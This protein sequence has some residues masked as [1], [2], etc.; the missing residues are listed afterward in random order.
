[1]K[2][3]KDIRELVMTGGFA[4]SLAVILAYVGVSINLDFL[5]RFHVNIPLILVIPFFCGAFVYFFHH[6]PLRAYTLIFVICSAAYTIAWVFFYILS[7]DVVYTFSEMLGF[8]IFI[9]LSFFLSI[10]G[11]WFTSAVLFRQILLFRTSYLETLPEE[12]EQLETEIR[13]LDTTITQKKTE[14]KNLYRMA[15]YGQNVW[16]E[17][18]NTRNN[19]FDLKWN[20]M[21]KKDRLIILTVFKTSTVKD[22]KGN[23]N[24]KVLPIESIRVSEARNRF[25]DSC[26]YVESEH[27]DLE[28]LLKRAK[29]GEGVWNLIKD[30]E[31]EIESEETTACKEGDTYIRLYARREL[32]RNNNILHID[33][34]LRNPDSV[35]H[36]LKKTQ[37][38]FAELKRMFKS[39][40]L[41]PFDEDM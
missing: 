3:D 5:S 8:T 35:Y 21:V 33:Y 15:E 25:L 31:E 16:D 4:L 41:P 27:K 9:I 40:F 34:A 18:D 39:T 20:K 30:I 37:R 26:R 36:R 6:I 11:Y 17:I 13:E 28:A 24:I 38:F 22:E 12:R 29:K 23:L 2:R 7:H 14:L 19:L 10:S 32:S 1:M